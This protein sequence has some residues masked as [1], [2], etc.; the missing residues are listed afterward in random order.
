MT[1]QPGPSFRVGIV[2]G[3]V[4]GLAT[5]AALLSRAPGRA[6]VD[7]FDARPTPFG[8][9]RHGVAP[10][11]PAGRRQLEEFAPLFDNP[12]VRFLGGIRVGHDLSRQELVASYDAVVYATGASEDRWLDVPGEDLPGVRSG[13]QFAEWYTGTPGAES[14]DLTGV[15]T[16]AIIGF[17]GVAVDLARILLKDPASLR[18]TD[19]PPEV[20]DHLAAHRVRDVTMLVRRGPAECHVKPDELADLLSLPGVG[21]RFDKTALDVDEVGLPD[22]IR[23]DLAVWRSA[24]G[25]EVLGAKARL[26]V[27]F[28]TR[29]MDFRGDDHVEGIRIE[30][31]RTDRGGRL[32]NAGES[33]HIPAQLVLRATGA[34]GSPIDGVPFDPISGVIPTRDHRVIDAAGLVQVGE[35]AAGWIAHGWASGFGTQRRDG[36]GVAAA[37]LADLDGH[38]AS[39]DAFLAARGLEPVGIDAWRRLDAAERALGESQGRE[40]ITIT[41]PT[42]LAELIDPAAGSS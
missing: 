3:G 2:G 37:I 42:V 11:H 30:R 12:L 8:L 16:V 20:L 26:R 10:D 9:L 15:T 14:F 18:D 29:A 13:R 27:R 38:S 1:E 41:D 39:I 36:A 28:W 35:Y 23:E 25:H 5:A 6:A 34:L 17:G 40:R 22:R 4:S 24:I 31:T 21:V 33:D 19:M 7:I 32:V